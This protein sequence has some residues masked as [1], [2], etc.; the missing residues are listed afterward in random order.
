MKNIILLRLS[1]WVAAIAG[2]IIA[3]SIL[4]PDRAGT[5]SYIYP[6]GLMSAVAFSWGIMLI[7]ADRKP[8]ERRWILIPTMLVVALLGFVS[9]HALITEIMPFSNVAPSV[10]VSIIVFI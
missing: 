1:Y 3:I 7:F 4:F 6:M 5:D 8:V 9:F 2:F 10:I